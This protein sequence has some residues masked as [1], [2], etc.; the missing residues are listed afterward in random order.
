MLPRPNKRAREADSE[1]EDQ[2]DDK[3]HNTSEKSAPKKAKTVHVKV[4]EYDDFDSPYKTLDEARVGSKNKVTCKPDEGYIPKE[5]EEIKAHVKG[6]FDVLVSTES[7]GGEEV[8]VNNKAKKGYGVLEG[9][10]YNTRKVSDIAWQLM[11]SDIHFY[12]LE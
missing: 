7:Y 6:F 11:V 1:V 2:A 8:P 3:A 9:E 5:F 10:D 4:K 12:R